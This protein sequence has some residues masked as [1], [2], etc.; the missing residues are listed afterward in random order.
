[1]FSNLQ[2]SR[3]LVKNDGLMNSFRRTISAE[4]MQSEWTEIQAA[5]KN[6]ALFRPLYDRYYEQIFQFIY[7]RTLDEER[8]ADICSQVFLKAMQRLGKYTYQG[9]PFSAWLF[10]IA[11]NEVAQHYRQAQKSRVVSMEDR[12]ISHMLDEMEEDNLAP[13]REILIGSLEELREEDL[14]ILELRFFEQRPF[15]EIADLLEITESN[16]KVRTYR[17]LERLKKIMLNNIQNSST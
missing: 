6:P 8:C 9:V 7:K 16:A 5:Q 12:D 1:M 11:S 13:Y 17:V 3:T 2:I 10:R 14:E 4:A 15:K